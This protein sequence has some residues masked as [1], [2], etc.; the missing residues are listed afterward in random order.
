LIS[1]ADLIE[2]KDRS[3]ATLKISAQK[4]RERE[5]KRKERKEGESAAEKEEKEED[6]ERKKEKENYIGLDGDGHD[7]RTPLVWA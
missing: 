7:R 3:G 5:K 6:E 2:D 4:L 1:N